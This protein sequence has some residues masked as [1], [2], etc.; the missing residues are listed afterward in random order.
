MPH[1][2]ESLL[3]A[4]RRGEMTAEELWQAVMT[5]DRSTWEREDYEELTALFLS[6]GGAEVAEAQRSAWEP[7]RDAFRRRAP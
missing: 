5:V 7:R 4:G 1:T 6:L 2:L 3:D